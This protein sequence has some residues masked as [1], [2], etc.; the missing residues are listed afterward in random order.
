MR[1][2]SSRTGCASAPCPA[3]R[4]TWAWMA[5]GSA[6]PWRISVSILPRVD[7]SGFQRQ[8]N[9][10][11]STGWPS[12]TSGA[13]AT[14][15]TR[16]GSPRPRTAVSSMPTPPP[17][18]TPKL[19]PGV[20]S[21]R[22]TSTSLPNCRNNATG[23]SPTRSTRPNSRWAKPRTRASATRAAPA[24]CGGTI[25][26]DPSPPKRKGT[27]VGAQRFFNA[28]MAM[29]A[30]K[31][32]VLCLPLVMASVESTMSVTT[33][34]QSFGAGRYFEVSNVSAARSSRGKAAKKAP[35]LSLG[36][37]GVIMLVPVP[38]RGIL[39]PPSHFSRARA[40]AR[41]WS[42]RAV[43]CRP[44]GAA[45]IQNSAWL[46]CARVAARPRC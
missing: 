19:L 28:P 9:P 29:A 33:S 14:S 31:F 8:D 35:S 40:N 11:R 25:T 21:K 4:I 23:A 24:W 44:G 16:A 15:C 30:T 3:S 43:S 7:C 2:L 12:S 37:A 10:A 38:V 46:L 5:P 13:M 18:K 6:A 45:S 39:A 26:T 1:R 27:G 42:A 17:R 36:A 41:P 20:G 34:T 32:T 22:P